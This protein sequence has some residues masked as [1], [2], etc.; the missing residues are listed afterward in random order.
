M[1][2]MLKRAL[3]SCQKGA[4]TPKVRYIIPWAVQH[5][6]SLHKLSWAAAISAKLGRASSRAIPEIRS[7]EGNAALQQLPKK[8]NPPRHPT[9][10]KIRMTFDPPMICT[11]FLKHELLSAGV[12]SMYASAPF[13]S[14]IYL[15]H[16]P[17][18][19]TYVTYVLPA[20]ICSITKRHCHSVHQTSVSDYHL[21][22]ESDWFL[23]CHTRT[24][25]ESQGMSFLLPDMQ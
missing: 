19:W 9:C 16:V 12:T 23:Y 22:I 6:I 2:N 3:R 24:Q 21:V 4:R 8:K 17:A 5:S 13:I 11:P 14:H 7:F 18:L 1:L 15:L 10:I 25:T 20:R